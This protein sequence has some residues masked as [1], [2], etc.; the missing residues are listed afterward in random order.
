MALFSRH[1]EVEVDDEDGDLRLI[2][3]LDD[4]RMGEPLHGVEVKM[5]VSVWEGEIKEISGSMPVVPLEECRG[6]LEAL[7]QLLGVNIKPGFS[8]L[9]RRT[10]GSNIGCTHLAALLMNMGNTSV[11]GRATY[12]RKHAPD[13]EAVREVLEKNAVE[14][15]LV[16]SCVCWAEDGPIIRRWR[17]SKKNT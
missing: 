2:G 14:L 4:T 15:G 8:D 7:D 13:E 11:Q 6:G 5:R 9:V 16:D 1:I 10:V 3:R 12:A 17:E